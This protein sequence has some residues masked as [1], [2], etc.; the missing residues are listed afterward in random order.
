MDLLACLLR[1]RACDNT[2]DKQ[3]FGGEGVVIGVSLWCVCLLGGLPFTS[4]HRSEGFF[5]MILVF[6]FTKEK[7]ESN[8]AWLLFFPLGV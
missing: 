6:F 8:H 7:E 5:A 4:S 1:M 3:L 2:R